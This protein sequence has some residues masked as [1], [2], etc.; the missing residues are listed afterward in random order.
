VSQLL[1][2][3]RSVNSQLA[4]VPGSTYV[5][6]GVDEVFERSEGVCQDFA[7]LAIAMCR[8]V[9][10]P[11]R[12]VSGFLFTSDDATGSDD[13]GDIAG[14]V[15]EVQTHAWFEASVPGF[16]WVALDPTNGR[17][18][19]LRHVAIGRGRDYDDVA[20]L[21]G[22]YAG[23]AGHELQTGVEIRRVGAPPPPAPPPPP[24][25]GRTYGSP[26]GPREDRGQLQQQPMDAYQ[27]QQQ[28]QQQ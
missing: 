13:P 12:Y 14:D 3:H 22:V 25:A 20:P 10:I 11:A 8:S 17:E 21:K 26:P 7:H 19:Q 23:V 9:G 28:Q 4:Y 27:Q 6:V 1:A 18:V 16:G 24:T 5:G 15:V 2:I